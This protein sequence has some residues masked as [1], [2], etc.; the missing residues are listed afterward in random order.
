[1][2]TAVEDEN[3]RLLMMRQRGAARPPVESV[4]TAIH[5]SRRVP[6]PHASAQEAA[7]DV[8]DIEMRRQALMAAEATAQAQAQHRGTTPDGIEVFAMP[9]ES[10]DLDANGSGRRGTSGGMPPIATPDPKKGTGNPR[11]RPPSVGR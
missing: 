5:E 11:F 1:M 8:R 3:M 4:L 9:A 10:L 2:S 6:P 7:E